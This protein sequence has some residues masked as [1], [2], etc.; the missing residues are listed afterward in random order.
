MKDPHARRRAVTILFLMSL[1]VPLKTAAQAAKGAG[2]PA[3]SPNQPASPSS[4]STQAGSTGGGGTGGTTLP[5]MSYTRSS[6]GLIN[7][8]PPPA[9]FDM[10]EDDFES[11]WDHF[12]KDSFR[13]NIIINCYVLKQNLSASQPFL[14]EPQQTPTASPGIKQLCANSSHKIKSRSLVMSRF[15]VF[16]IDLREIKKETRDRIQTMNINVTAQTGNSLNAQRGSPMNPTPT[17]PSMAFLSPRS[18]NC[19]TRDNPQIVKRVLAKYE[20][21]DLPLNEALCPED[22]KTADIYYLSWP[23][24]LIG[25]TTPTVSINLIYTPVAPGL[26]WESETFYPAGSVVISSTNNTTNGHY[27]VAVNG[28]GY[29]SGQPPF[30]ANA[31]PVPIFK[32]S[33]GV[34]WKDMGQK[35]AGDTY[36]YWKKENH[37]FR[38]DHVVPQVPNGHYYHAEVSGMSGTREPAF[39]RDG[40]TVYDTEGL[41]WEYV[42]R[43]QQQS[44]N[45]PTQTPQATSTSNPPSS[46][47]SNSA[48]KPWVPGVSFVA[49]QQIV[50]PGIANG[51]YYEAVNSGISGQRPPVFPDNGGTVCDGT[52]ANGNCRPQ[53]VGGV[54]WRDMGLLPKTSTAPPWT[55]S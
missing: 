43:T 27:Y 25:D 3:Q 12:S 38:D 1:F 44:T 42:G 19:K 20:L 29:G 7:R 46:A 10:A 17:R 36:P 8:L 9:T 24:E 6:W 15:L 11:F 18:Y 23:G 22:P 21:G 34:Y 2:N 33:G 48:F 51:H 30:S 31:N 26:E 55:P 16:R 45:P 53:G 52:L 28:G 39:P 54:E 47:A 4:N 35:P 37:Y 50:P 13:K 5:G 32:D 40:G 49:G 14:M 41:T